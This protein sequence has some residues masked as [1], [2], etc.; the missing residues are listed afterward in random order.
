MQER[1][2][3]LFLLCY[4]VYL[5]LKNLLM[6][7]GAY[8]QTNIGINTHFLENN[9][10]KPAASCGHAPGLNICNF[11]VNKDHINKY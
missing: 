6:W 8:G 3:D 5:S 4:R 10:N 7:V 1:I 11:A 2:E 9:F